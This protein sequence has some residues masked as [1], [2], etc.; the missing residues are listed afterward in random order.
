MRDLDIEVENYL[1]KRMVVFDFESITVHD[2]FLNHTDSTTFIGKHVPVNVSTHSNFISEPIFNC[3]INLR[4]LVS[5]FILEL[6]ALSKISSF[7]WRQ[8]FEPYFQLI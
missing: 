2:Q 8:L 3:D 4:S 6:L 1:L 7:E 5:K